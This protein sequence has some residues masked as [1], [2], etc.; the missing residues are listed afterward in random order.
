MKKARKIVFTLLLALVLLYLGQSLY[1]SARVYSVV[2]ASLRSFGTENTTSVPVDD[3]V[4]ARM[5]FR[6]D[7]SLSAADHPECGESITLGFPLTLH[8][9]TGARSVYLYSYELS[10][11]S[12]QLIGGSWRIPVTV[13]S[14]FRRGRLCITAY[15]EPV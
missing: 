7:Y 9:F 3:A 5:C 10:D 15:T 4:F 6:D 13:Y 8:W 1:I 14:E 2:R 12:G 11:G